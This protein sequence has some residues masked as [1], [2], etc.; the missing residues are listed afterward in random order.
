M[1]AFWYFLCLMRLNETKPARFVNEFRSWRAKFFFYTNNHEYAS[2]F[3]H[4]SYTI[5][6]LP[7]FITVKCQQVGHSSEWGQKNIEDL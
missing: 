5:C 7:K 6:M 1:F 4:R 2:F 3:F